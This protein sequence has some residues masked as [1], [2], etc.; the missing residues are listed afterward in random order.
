MVI[1]RINDYA[2]KIKGDQTSQP[3]PPKTKKYLT[4]E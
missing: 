3:N 1:V 4:F 2:C